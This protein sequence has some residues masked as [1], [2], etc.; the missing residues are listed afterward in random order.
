VM[1]WEEAAQPARDLGVRLVL[2]RTG[3]VLGSEGA[4]PML[5]LPVRCFVGGPI[6]SGRQ[7]MPWVHV[8]DVVGLA[9]FA[10]EC[11][12]LS[13][14]INVC[15]PEPVRNR[16]LMRAIGKALRRPSW[17]AAPAPLLRFV[18]GEVSYALL[19]SQRVVPAVAQH[20]GYRFREPALLPA[21]RKALAAA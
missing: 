5:A 3:V 4:L 9:R 12:D 15:A 17:I 2:L 18:A 1:D 11:E 14:P 7:W 19:S 16:D 21:V 6:A 8:D 20:L 13:G 10:I